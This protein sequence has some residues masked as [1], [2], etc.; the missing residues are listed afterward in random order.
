MNTTIDDDAVVASP[1]P[2]LRAIHRGKG[3]RTWLIVLV[4]LVLAS[5]LAAIVIGSSSVDPLTVL[6]ILCWRAFSWGDP[7]LWTPRQEA[8]VLDIRLPR[9]LVGL[10]AGAALA[11]CGATLQTLVRNPLADPYILGVSAGA[12]AGAAAVILFGGGLLVGAFGLAGSAFAGAALATVLVLMLAHSGGRPTAMRMLLAGVTVGYLL[13]AATSFLIFASDTPEG[14]RTV[15]FWLLGSLALAS[16]QSLL[17]LTA[18]VVIGVAVLMTST[19]SLDALDLGDETAQ[20]LGIRP[21]RTRR[22]LLLLCAALIGVTVSAVG[23]IGFV[24]LVVPHLARRLVGTAHRA[25]IPAAALIGASFL[26]ISDVVA[27]TVLYPQ[28]LPIGI[29]TALVGTP[30]LIRHVARMRDG[31]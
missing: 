18:V 7:T 11:V 1:G 5:T 29:V 25:L 8:I 27:R 26:V 10:V 9:V 28:D 23:A 19:R 2:D 22:R 21:D 14:A 15:M 24:G 4:V 13:Q 6:R 16:K 12:S 17:V 31:V 30:L 3:R 20:S